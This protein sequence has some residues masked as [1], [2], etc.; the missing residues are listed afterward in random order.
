[1]SQ[2]LVAMT[3]EDALTFFAMTPGELLKSVLD[4]RKIR[5]TDF[6]AS[7]GEKYLTIFRWTKNVGFSAANQRRAAQA[8]DLDPDYFARVFDDDVARAREANRRKVFAQFC[9]T[10]MG[11][12]LATEEPSILKA[13]NS[14][15]FPHG[16]RPTVD[17]FVGLALVFL[18]QLDPEE[19][20]S[21]VK[22]NEALKAGPERKPKRKPG[23]KPK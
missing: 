9:E 15:P 2:R 10:D 12:R 18:R 21:A 20:Q 14:T 7:I 8:L 13:L 11:K 4:E 16:R 3:D 1:M 22:L 23:K 6:G 17:A 5:K 19:L